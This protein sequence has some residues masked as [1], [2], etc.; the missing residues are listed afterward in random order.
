MTNPFLE[1]VIKCGKCGYL[2]R[3]QDETRIKGSGDYKRAL[4]K[5]PGKP[6]FGTICFSCWLGFKDAG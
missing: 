3:F 1:D 4:G 5:F 2:F 6:L